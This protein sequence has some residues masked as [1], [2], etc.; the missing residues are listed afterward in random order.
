MNRIA[1]GNNTLRLGA[2]FH[3]LMQRQRGH[4]MLQLGAANSSAAGPPEDT[5]VMALACKP[6]PLRRQEATLLETAASHPPGQTPAFPA[7]GN[8]N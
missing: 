7:A 2:C 8:Y 3:L 6:V 1:G 5:W 4:Y